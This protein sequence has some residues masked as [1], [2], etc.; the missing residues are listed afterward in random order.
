MKKDADCA[1][2]RRKLAPIF[3]SEFALNIMRVIYYIY[4]NIFQIDSYQY[5]EIIKVVDYL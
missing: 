3:L 5:D 4:I 1:E 2:M